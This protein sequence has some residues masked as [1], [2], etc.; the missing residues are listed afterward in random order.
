[1][2]PRGEVRLAIAHA[3]LALFVERGGF[4]W[5]EAAERAQVGYS[6]AKQTVR[7]MCG[8][9][10]LVKVDAVPVSGSRRPMVRYVP[11]SGGW[12]MS[13]VAGDMQSVMRNWVMGR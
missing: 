7:N 3:G 5:K 2:R 13:A 1:M 9:G 10:E 8:A 11:G 6:V 12:V 4:T